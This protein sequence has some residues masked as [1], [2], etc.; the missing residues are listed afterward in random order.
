MM[1]YKFQ[2]FHQFGCGIFKFSFFSKNPEYHTSFL[3][4]SL[5]FLSDFLNHMTSFMNGSLFISQK[6]TSTYFSQDLSS[7]CF[8]LPHFLRLTHFRDRFCLHFLS[9][10]PHVLHCENWI[11]FLW[12]ETLLS[13]PTPLSSLSLLL[14][15]SWLKSLASFS[16]VVLLEICVCCL[17]KSTSLICKQR[18]KVC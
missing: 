18:Q 8:T 10:A 16:L 14:I 4:S 7:I 12:A 2:D 6:I 1:I 11:N 13:L 3:N 9:Q 15:S 5:Y 17:L